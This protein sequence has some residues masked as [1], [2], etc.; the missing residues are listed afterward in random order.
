MKL[1]KKSR[2]AWIVFRNTFLDKFVS[3]YKLIH[4][5]NTVFGSLELNIMDYWFG[6]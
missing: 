1:K 4:T 2:F 5:T 6:G 3:E